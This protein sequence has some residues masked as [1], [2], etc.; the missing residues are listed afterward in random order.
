VL[1]LGD[2]KPLIKIIH[3]LEGVGKTSLITTIVKDI[4][5]KEVP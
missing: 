2:S 3:F 4:F 1:F 5:P